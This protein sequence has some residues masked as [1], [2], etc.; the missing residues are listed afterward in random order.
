[1][2]PKNPRL[3]TLTPGV[4]AQGVD[5]LHE[6]PGRSRVSRA[7]LPGDLVE[8]VVDAHADGAEPL[9]H[10]AI[11]A[12]EDVEAERQGGDREQ[13][14]HAATSSASG[15]VS[16][17]SAGRKEAGRWT[18]ERFYG[19]HPRRCECGVAE[20][21]RLAPRPGPKPGQLQR[22]PGPFSEFFTIVL[23]DGARFVLFLNLDEFEAFPDRQSVGWDRVA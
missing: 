20:A 19:L 17:R 12:N 21:A 13:D 1:M 23:E 3:V 16:R 18:C 5:V 15:A 11:Q 9:G 10:G 22:N 6:T 2:V 4:A 7:D 14:P 8:Q